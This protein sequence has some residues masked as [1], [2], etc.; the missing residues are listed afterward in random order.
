MAL[1]LVSTTITDTHIKMRIADHKDTDKAT[2]WLEFQ[3]PLKDLEITLSATAK[4][5]LSDPEIVQLL[6]V[7][8]AALR[9]ARDVIGAETQ[10]YAKLRDRSD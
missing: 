10:R 9:R 6:E 5:P 4:M 3:V 7:H 8:L 1:S 2:Q